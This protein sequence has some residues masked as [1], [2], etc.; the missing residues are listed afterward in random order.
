[1]PTP[2]TMQAI[3]IERFGGVEELR[4]RELPVPEPGPGQVRVRVRAVSVNPVDWKM[5]Q[6]RAGGELPLVLG[7]DAAGFVD[8]L[9]PGV[10]DVE[11]GQDVIA[12]LLGPRSNGAYAQFAC[13]PR[14]F[15]GPKPSSLRYQQAAAIP[16][17]AMTAYEALVLKARLRAGEPLF[18]AGGAGGVGS[19]AIP[20]ARRLGASPIITTAGSDASADFIVRTLEVPREHILRY[21]GLGLDELERRA[22]A[23]N[24]GQ[25]YSTVLDLV[26]GDMKRLCCRL[27]DFDGHM[28][29]IVEEPPGFELGVWQGDG[30]LGARSASLHRVSLSAR[31]RT[32]PPATWASYRD[33]LESLSHWYETGHLPPPAITVLGALSEATIRAAHTRLE[34]GHVQGKLVLTVE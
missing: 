11:P 17:A 26:G 8:A 5:R 3:V 14:E 7:R 30:F 28:V 22:L 32:G 24:G 10:R 9:G 23:L 2:S 19:V 33:E 15:I 29:T 27:V 12:A 34:A 21:A 31:A 16:V 6:G 18:I 20:L 13:V 1:M 4:A 25:P